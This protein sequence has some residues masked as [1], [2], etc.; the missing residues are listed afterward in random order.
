MM[1]QAHRSPWGGKRGA[2]HGA[3]QVILGIAVASGK[4]GTGE[5]QDGLDLNSGPALRQQVS[6]DPEIYDAPIRLRKAFANVPSLHTSLVD[7][8]GRCGVD[9][10][11]I[12]CG[13]VDRARRGGRLYRFAD[14]LQQR[15]AATRQ[16]GTG[17]DESHPRG[18]AVGCVSCGLLIGESSEPSQVTPV[19]AGRIATVE[20]CQ[21]PA[22]GSRHGR[23]QG[24]GA[25]V[26]P[27]LK[28]ARAGLH[29]HTRV[30]S[31]AAHEVDSRR[32]GTIQ[33]DQTEA[34]VSV[35]GVGVKID[36]T[37]LAVASPQKADGSGA[38]QL[39]G[40]PESF[41]GKWTARS[42]VNQADQIEIA[43]H[44]GQLSANGLPGE[45]ETA[46]FHDRHFALGTNRRTMD[47]QRTANCVL[48]VCLSRG[49]KCK[50]VQEFLAGKLLVDDLRQAVP[51]LVRRSIDPRWREAV[52]LGLGSL[53]ES[54]STSQLIEVC[55]ELLAA[56][57]GFVPTGAIIMA[58]LVEDRPS[59]PDT[60]ITETVVRL[61]E[62]YGQPGILRDQVQ[63]RDMTENFVAGLLTK[64]T[65]PASWK[66]AAEK[67]ALN[68]AQ[69]RPAQNVRVLAGLLHKRGVANSNFADTLLSALHDDRQDANWIVNR[70]LE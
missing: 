10:V 35:S 46:V 25:E 44:C 9:R 67:G 4:M 14:G 17:V 62:A 64:P 50:T 8:D 22:G 57:D 37:P 65:F 68:F 45:K 53:C 15:L 1:W 18:V 7:G 24:R 40:C 31:V 11:R 66:A 55:R 59:L 6:G 49:G 23:L 69:L 16:T 29:H 47:I 61:L 43:G 52:L 12:R 38:H 28:M 56:Q 34:S 5:A 58:Q 32:I 70:A 51:N 39:G 30:M 3:A 48:T 21:V 26:D 2:C 36:V 54:L 19:G 27:R 63:F 42:V 60:I 13:P 33:I 20:M 41:A